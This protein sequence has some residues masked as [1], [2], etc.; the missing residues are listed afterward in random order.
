MRNFFLV[1]CLVLLFST[2]CQ[3]RTVESDETITIGN[4]TAADILNDDHEADIFQYNNLIYT[5]AST[6]EWVQENTYERGPEIYDVR[7]QSI[8]SDEF[9]DGTASKLPVGTRIFQVVGNGQVLLMV[10]KDGEEVVYLAL[11]EGWNA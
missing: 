3:M 1:I 10:E 8:E 11:I 6:I 5:N 2:G 7:K 4:P 9:S